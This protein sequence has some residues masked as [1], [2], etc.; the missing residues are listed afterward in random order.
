MQP[1]AKKRPKPEAEKLE[2]K[3]QRPRAPRFWTPQELD[4]HHE[5]LEKKK[6]R[7]RAPRFWTPQ[8]LDLH[9]EELEKKKQRPRAP[10][11][12]TPE[13]LDLLHEE[14]EKKQK[15]RDEVN[16]KLKQQA[17][18]TGWS[19][20]KPV[21]QLEP[22]VQQKQRP[23]KVL[24]NKKHLEALKVKKTI[25]K[26]IAKPVVTPLPAMDVKQVKGR[27]LKMLEVWGPTMKRLKDKVPPGESLGLKD[28]ARRAED[29]EVEDIF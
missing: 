24:Q 4:L 15:A 22:R 14:L 3:K 13:E 17:Q 25:V 16:E 10:R 7:P 9:H 27:L 8:E 29:T 6:Q 12:W 1:H 5:E 11:S 21:G 2:K 28:E 20:A 26:A 18:E 19:V 23:S